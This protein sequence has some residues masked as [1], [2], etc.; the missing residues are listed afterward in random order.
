M[1]RTVDR[2]NAR[3]VATLAKSSRHADGGGLYL[4]ISGDGTT[5]R[6]RWVFLFRWRGKLKEMGLGGARTVS[7]ANAREM[8]VDARSEIAAGRNPIESRDAARR[9]AKSART[10]SDVAQ[11][12]YDSKSAGWKNAKVR[13][14]WRAPLD[15]YACRLNAL[16]I[17]AIKTDDVLAVLRPIWSQKPETASRVRGRIEAVIDAARAK[18]LIPFN[19]ANPARWRGHLDHLLPH[20]KRLSRGHH[21]AMPYEEVPDFFTNLRNL[22]S[23]SASALEFTILT[24]TR[25]GE[26]LGATWAE[27]DPVTK[28]WTIPGSRMKSGREHRVPLSLRA[29][30]ILEKCR[31]LGGEGFVFQGQRLGRP[32]SVMS[33]AMLLRRMSVEVTVHG[34]RSSFRDWAGEETS[35]PREIA[36][37]AL[38]HVV[39]DAVELAYRRGDALERRRAIMEEWATFSE[40]TAKGNVLALRATR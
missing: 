1:A 40:P 13:K 2:L 7:L 9:A 30:A 14:Q 10:F 38:A 4:A 6:R 19:D 23:V 21:A 20:R 37:Q 8:A 35:Y 18:G 15:R 3:L 27:I 33:M 17:E 5:A 28:V 32:L 12:F 29:L 24:A 26:V 34:F 22:R 36:E 16:P 31:E 11:E 39:G 25:T